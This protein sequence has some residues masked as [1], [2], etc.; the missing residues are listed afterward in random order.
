MK[1]FPTLCI[2][3]FYD[4]PNKVRDFALSLDYHD[5]NGRYPGKRT[6]LLHEIDKKFFDDFCLKFFSLYYNF[7]SATV[8]WTVE[9]EFQLIHTFEENKNSPKNKGWIHIDTS[10]ILAGVIYLTPEI[11]EDCG[12][13]VFDIIDENLPLNGIDVK[14]AF[15]EKGIDNNY[16]ETLLKYNSCFKETIKF[17]NIYNR[18]ISYDG[19]SYHG[20]N[21]FYSKEPRLTQVF[22]VKKIG[23]DHGTPIERSKLIVM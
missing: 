21:S 18:L 20:V 19:T 5:S 6:N 3:N 22:F 12:T 14:T 11:D 13:S 7:N 16:D 15:Y 4:D 10:S 2:D 8:E 1:L 17:K 9:T 23:T